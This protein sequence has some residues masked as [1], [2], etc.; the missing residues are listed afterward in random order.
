MTHNPYG[1]KV[2]DTVI[3]DAKYEVKI[4]SF[5]PNKMFTEV[6]SDCPM[7]YVMTNRLTPLTTPKDK[8]KTN[9]RH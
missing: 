5:T 3:L 2:G 1:L 6:Q 9:D 4:I 8:N 7:W